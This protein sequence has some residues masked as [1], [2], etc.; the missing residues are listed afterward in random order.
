MFHSINPVNNQVLKSFPTLND[1]ELEDKVSISK[2]TFDSFWK[3]TGIETRIQSIK[4]VKENLKENTSEYAKLITLEMGKPITQSLAEIEKCIF[5]C[6]YYCSNAKAFLEDKI[7]K[8]KASKSFVTYQPLGAV[9][10]I[11]PWNFP[12]WQVFR[13]SI[14]SLL[15]GNVVLLKHAPNVP[16]CALAIEKIFHQA[17]DERG[18]FQT[19]F[20]EIDQVEKVISNKIVQGVTLTGSDRAGSSVAALA[21]KY[22]KKC[23]LELGGTDPFIVLKDADLEQAAHSAIKSR[24]NNCGQTC[25]SAKRMI[26]DETITERFTALLSKEISNLKIGDPFDPNT[27]I[28]CLARPDLTEN[29]ERQVNSSIDQG[30]VVVKKGGRRAKGGNYFEPIILTNIKRTMAVYKEEVFGPAA[31]VL[32]FKDEKEAI[33]LA[34]DSDYGLGAAVWSNDLQRAEKIGLKLEAGAIAINDMVKSDPRLPFGG[35]KR[36][37]FGRELALEGIREFVNIKSISIS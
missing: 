13:Y 21:G 15:A 37:G 22:I 8:T 19:L 23:V 14:P 5:L 7:V 36:S 29:L 3:N 34:N 33:D 1:N 10:G 28:S 25:I 20:I 6:E 11:M 4:K 30:A 27:E 12:F 9:F 16:Q 17:I 32:T 18:V 31:I 2:S 24:M 35:V 26:V